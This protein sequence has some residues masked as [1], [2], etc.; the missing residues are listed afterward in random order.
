MA[1]EGNGVYRTHAPAYQVYQPG[2]DEVA[3][4]GRMDTGNMDLMYPFLVNA[5]ARNAAVQGQYEAQ[6]GAANALQ[7]QIAQQK[8]AEDARKANLNFAA[9]MVQ[10]GRSNPG[11]FAGALGVPHDPA[12]LAGGDNLNVVAHS[13]EAL[14][15]VGQGM[16]AAA[17]AGAPPMPGQRFSLNPGSLMQLNG[18]STLP[19]DLRTEAMKAAAGGGRGPQTQVDVG[20]GGVPTVRT[21]RLP[22]A[23]GAITA[24]VNRARTELG[25]PPLPSAGGS[26]VPAGAQAGATG[27]TRTR[28]TGGAPIPAAPTAGNAGGAPLPP[29]VAARLTQASRESGQ[30]LT[31]VNRGDGTYSFVAPGGREVARQR[32]Q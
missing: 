29:N 22:D 26:P 12:A 1:D 27:T 28:P 13:A 4:I 14:R 20:A 6:L 11:A 16:Q 21:T 9:S 30:S 19:L 23:P 15:N 10:H 17:E 2:N 32:V 8:L 18:T 31:A 5:R 25:L 3:T 24:A 7:Q